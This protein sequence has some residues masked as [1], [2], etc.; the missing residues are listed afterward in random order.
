MNAREPILDCLVIGGGAAG[1]TAAVYLARY[2]RTLRVI[3]EGRSRLQWIPKTR[4]VMGFPDGVAGSV[5]W[6]R[7]RQHAARYG[8]EPEPGRV[9]S[10]VL[11]EDGA[12]EAGVDGRRLLARKVLLATGA[13]DVEPVV[14]GLREGLAHGQVRYCPVCDGFETQGQRVAVMGPGLHGLRESLFVSGFDN[15][16]TWLSM[17]SLQAVSADQAGRLRGCGVQVHDGQPHGIACVPGAEVRVTMDDGQ[18]LVFDTLYPALGQTHASALAVRLG[19]RCADDGQLE[20]DSHLRTAV[21]GLFAA[22]DVAQGLNQI[23]VAAGQAAI[24]ATAIHNSL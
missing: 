22:G 12:F 11:R 4:N 24:A 23:S 8:I 2:R 14:A 18:V 13:S 21:P 9:E 3:D 7:L 15:R 10:L 1:L 19:A 5:L 16:V 17:G 6:D 20:V